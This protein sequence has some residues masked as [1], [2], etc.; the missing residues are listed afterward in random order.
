[1]IGMS[2]HKSILKSASVI[3]GFTMLSRMTG[4][5]R[6]VLLAGL[7]G[8]GA[9]I[10]AF[11]VAFRIPNMFRDIMGEGAGNAAFVPVF[12]EY[13]QVRSR[14]EFLDLVHKIFFLL[15]VS[16]VA[17]VLVGIV[18]SPFIVRLVAPG[19]VGD[20]LKFSLSVTLNRILF[21]YLLLV[22]ISAF[23]MSVANAMKSFAVPAATSVTFNIVMIAGLGSMGFVD[24]GRIHLLAVVVL[25]AGVAQIVIQ[26]P[27]LA[28]RGVTLSVH[29]PHGVWRD[30]GVRRI[31]R[32]MGPRLLGTSIYQMNIFV[33]TIVA[34]LSAA[35]GDGAIA[36]IYFANRLVYLPFSLFGVA[37]SNAA[38]PNLSLHAAARD[39]EAFR[40]LLSFSLRVVFLGVAPFFVAFLLLAQPLVEA[41]FE[42]GSFSAYSTQITAIAVVFY[43]MGLF[44]YVGVRLL[45]HAFYALQ[46]TRTPVKGAGAGLGVNVVLISVFVFWWRWGVAGLALSSALGATANCVWLAM[47]MRRRLRF[48]FS[49]AFRNILFRACAAAGVMGCVVHVFWYVVPFWE[50]PLVKMIVTT[51]LGAG[52]FIGLLRLMRV[53]EIEDVIR[54]VLKKK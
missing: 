23:L 20:A 39:Y 54:W 1:V 50:A 18:F 45:S 15:T 26:L 6:D 2:E 47:A 28:R 10:Q 12:C 43:A 21:P 11:F 9:E 49:Q 30:P 17:V 48:S 36:A 33:D 46:D 5:I 38:L 22:A 34:S 25:L 41:I 52:V 13:L 53:R 42:R 8:T 37:V 27:S 14:R 4:F 35:A 40:S 7:F 16:S 3:S 31:G 24:Q 19:F 32:L 51:F 29:R 44:S